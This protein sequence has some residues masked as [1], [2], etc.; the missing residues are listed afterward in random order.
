MSCEDDAVGDF[1]DG[2]GDGSAVTV[3]SRN[4]VKAWRVA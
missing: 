1:D 3:A 4:S 2:E